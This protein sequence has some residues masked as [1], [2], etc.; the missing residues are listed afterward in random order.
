M[1]QSARAE[2]AL[3]APCLNLKQ[4]ISGAQRRLIEVKRHDSNGEAIPAKHASRRAFTRSR[5]GTSRSENHDSAN[6]VEKGSSA[7]N[8]VVERVLMRTR[9]KFDQLDVNGN[10]LLARR[11]L[12]GLTEWVWSSFHPGGEQLSTKQQAEESSKLMGQLNGDDNMSFLEF[13][14]WF[15]RTC[16]GIERY[17]RGLVHMQNAL[18]GVPGIPKLGAF[19]TP[20]RQSLVPASPRPASA[21][22]KVRL[23]LIVVP[24]GSTIL[25]AFCVWR[26]DELHGSRIHL[27]V[28]RLTIH[29]VQ[30]TAMRLGLIM[31]CNFA[32]TLRKVRAGC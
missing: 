27:L 30:A 13:A 32:G 22:F 19:G 31:L 12:I 23:A 11:Q 24:V 14:A 5:L 18:E 3:D 7:T 4:R 25:A 10:G 17:R 9:K 26:A 15:R 1:I 28:N 6:A 29:Y 8:A 2:A 21:S 16:S 20:K